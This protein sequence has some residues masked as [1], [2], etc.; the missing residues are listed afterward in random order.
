MSAVCQDHA[1]REQRLQAILSFLTCWP[2]FGLQ[3]LVPLIV[4]LVSPALQVWWKEAQH[5]DFILGASLLF[6]SLLLYS[7]SADIEA[8]EKTARAAIPVTFDAGALRWLAIILAALYMLGYAVVTA[9]WFHDPQ[10][11][12]AAASR[13]IVIQLLFTIAAAIFATTGRIYCTKKLAA[14]SIP[15]GAP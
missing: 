11:V 10:R 13:F 5:N 3:V 9:L 7:V 6:S 2:W 14:L 8:A 1:C 4:L 12:Q 15:G